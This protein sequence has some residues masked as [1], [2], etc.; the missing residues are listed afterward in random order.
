MVGINISWLIVSSRAMSSCSVV[1]SDNAILRILFTSLLTIVSQTKNPSFTS[2]S[3]LQWSSS[4]NNLDFAVLGNAL[5]NV[6]VPP[7]APLARMSWGSSS[8]PDSSHASRIEDRLFSNSNGASLII[9]NAEP[10]ARLAI[11]L[12]PSGGRMLCLISNIIIFLFALLRAWWKNL[13]R[14]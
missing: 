4:F 10:S 11:C 13:S 6:G 1:S 7:Y 9:D 3:D 2:V 14:K 12:F 5:Q 8:I